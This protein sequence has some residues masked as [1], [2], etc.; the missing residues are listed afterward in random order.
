MSSI[1]NILLASASPRRSH[2]LQEHNYTFDVCP[3]NVEEM[4]NVDA[5]PVVL[6]THNSS[7]KADFISRLHPERLVLGADTTVALDEH[8]LNKPVDLADAARMLKMLSGR[9]HTVYTGVALQCFE[10]KLK[11]QR[12]VESRVVFKTLSEAR[13]QEYFKIVNPLD[14]AGAYGIQE[15]KEMIID[16]FE[17]SFSNIM[18]LPM[19]ALAEMMSAAEAYL[20][21]S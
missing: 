10:K 18:G 8:V 16:H 20:T 17:G 7:I 14:K 19:E 5:D 12:V 2:L 6:V 15:G 3:A 13:I 1:L 21:L 11:M 9:A 4:E